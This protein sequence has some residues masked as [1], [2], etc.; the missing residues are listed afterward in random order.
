MVCVELDC[1]VNV[2]MGLKGLVYMVDELV[3]V[4]VCWV[5]VG[6]LFVCVV[7]VGLMCVVEEVCQYGI[8]GY[9]DVVL[10]G[11]RIVVIMV[12]S[13]GCDRV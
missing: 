6:G 4:G 12:D 2:V 8:F 11:V 13:L 10:L 1:F 7:L 9:V 5:S 3:C